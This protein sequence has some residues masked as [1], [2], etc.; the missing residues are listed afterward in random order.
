ML[1]SVVWLLDCWGLFVIVLFVWWLIDLQL[2]TLGCVLWFVS[3][4]VGV[5][6]RVVRWLGGLSKWSGLVGFAIL[7]SGFWLRLGLCFV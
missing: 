5:L 3:V 1:L 6:L 4:G 2:A 7:V